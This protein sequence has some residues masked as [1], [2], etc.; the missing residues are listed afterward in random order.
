MNEID[1]VTLR[2]ETVLAFKAI[3]SIKTVE[4]REGNISARIPDMDEFFVTLSYNNYE[5]M[6]PVDVEH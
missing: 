4:I 2:M 5:N 1:L 6:N 3:M